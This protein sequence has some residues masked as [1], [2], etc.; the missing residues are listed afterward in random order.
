MSAPISTTTN[1]VSQRRSDR[2]LTARPATTPD[3]PGV[4]PAVA[5]S[6]DIDSPF[7]CP[8]RPRGAEADQ[9]VER[10]RG[11]QQRTGD[12]RIPERRHPD[13]HERLVDDLEEDGSERRADDVAAAPE[14]GDAADDDR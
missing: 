11:E 6:A 2:Q 10:D 4:G 8:H 13:R 14:D 7:L 3:P 5:V 9:P 12:R 1:A